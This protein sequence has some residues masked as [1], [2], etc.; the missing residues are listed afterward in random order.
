MLGTD[1]IDTM[2]KASSVQPYCSAVMRI[3]ERD[4][5]R[6][7]SDIFRPRSVNLPLLSRA[8]RIHSWYMAFKIVSSGGGSMK[9]KFV[10]SSIFRLFSNNTTLARLVLWISGMLFL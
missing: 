5:S 9:L 4:G 10:R 7:N 2:V 8:P 3:F 1:S 6:G